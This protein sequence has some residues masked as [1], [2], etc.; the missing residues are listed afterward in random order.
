MRRGTKSL[1]FGVHQVA[2]HPAIVALAFRRIYRRWPSWREAVCIVVHDW[3]YWGCEAMDGP[4]GERHPYLGGQIAGRL[5]GVGWKHW[6][7]AHS[8]TLARIAGV[9]VSPLCAPDKLSSALYPR[10]LYLALARASGELAEYRKNAAEYH[11]RTGRG[12]PAEASD[13]AWFDW[14]AECMRKAARDSD[15]NPPSTDRR[16]WAVA[17]EPGDTVEPAPAGGDGGE[18]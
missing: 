8:R 5:L 1:L 4:D 6:T 11:A 9:E 3:G 7:A 17:A 12:C 13:E 10:R 15:G 18:G 16:L 14:M 2:L